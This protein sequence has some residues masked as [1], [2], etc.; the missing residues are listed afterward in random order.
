[1]APGPVAVLWTSYG[2]ALPGMRQR[3]S[4]DTFY[5]MPYAYGCVF[6]NLAKVQ[7]NTRAKTMTRKMLNLC[8]PMNMMSFT[9]TDHVARHSGTSV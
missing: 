5:F 3:R 1:M 7:R 8:I 4:T 9:L 2:V 6:P